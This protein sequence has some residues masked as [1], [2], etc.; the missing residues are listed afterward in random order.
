LSALSKALAP[1]AVQVTYCATNALPFRVEWRAARG[2][3]TFYGLSPDDAAAAAQEAL[4]RGTVERPSAR[5]HAPVTEPSGNTPWAE[6]MRDYIAEVD[7]QRR[8]T[9]R[10][11]LRIVRGADR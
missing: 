10:P 6:A 1:A 3:V 8:E 5:T 4:A 9:R 11:V 2:P 7:E